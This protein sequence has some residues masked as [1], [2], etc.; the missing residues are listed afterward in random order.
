[1]AGI[2]TGVVRAIRG[3][4]PSSSAVGFTVAIV[5]GAGGVLIAIALAV[6]AS[7]RHRF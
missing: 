3:P 5:L 4:A 6:T 2:S 1:M 7:R